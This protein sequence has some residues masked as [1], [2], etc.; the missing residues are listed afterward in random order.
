MPTH[1]Y[2]AAFGEAASARSFCKIDLFFLAHMKLLLS[3]PIT[4]AHAVANPPRMFL[5]THMAAAHVH[6][7]VLHIAFIKQRKFHGRPETYSWLG[8]QST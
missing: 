8:S 3:A 1:S 5:Q 2:M 4:A 7:R 6:A